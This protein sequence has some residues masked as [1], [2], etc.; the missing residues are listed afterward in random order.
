MKKAQYTWVKKNENSFYI[1][2]KETYTCD[3][4]GDFIV[5]LKGQGV[6]WEMKCAFLKIKD[7]SLFQC[8]L[9]DAQKKA[10]AYVEEEL[11]NRI[12]LYKSALALV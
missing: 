1:D 3:F 9:S 12:K 7:I 4:G 2:S 8:T 6:T 11:K 10:I 5:Q